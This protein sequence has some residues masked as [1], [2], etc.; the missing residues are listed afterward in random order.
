MLPQEE[1]KVRKVLFTLQ[2]RHKR[3][4]R[5]HNY[6]IRQKLSLVILQLPPTHGYKLFDALDY[7]VWF[8]MY[9][10]PRLIA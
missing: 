1:T 10:S 6:Y 9:R 5:Y 7:I 3:N 2:R 4:A 8:T